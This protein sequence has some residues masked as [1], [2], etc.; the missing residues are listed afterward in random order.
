MAEARGREFA[1]ELLSDVHAVSRFTC[2]RRPG[3]AEIDVY[4]K[5]LASI[6]QQLGLASVR[7]AVDLRSETAHRVAGFFTLSPLSVPL[8]AVVLSALGLDSAPYRNVGGFL[9]GRLGVDVDYQGRQLGSL[10]VAAAI[11]LARKA[12]GDVGGVFLAIDPKSEALLRWYE[13]LDFG[14]TRLNPNDAA[15]RRLVLRL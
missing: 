12:Q 4:L 5:T 8:S 13:Q 6:E 15:K 7:V 2:G 9:L 14:F 11:S 1:L 10:L 3:S